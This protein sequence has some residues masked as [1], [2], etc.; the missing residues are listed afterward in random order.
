MSQQMDTL[1][2]AIEAETDE[3]KKT[4]LQSQWDSIKA[5]YDALSAQLSQQ[6]QTLADK[7]SELSGQEQTLADKESELTAAQESLNA[8]KI[9]Y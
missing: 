2:A 5:Q 1:S 3:E 8:A 9:S 7:E 6:E 4:Q